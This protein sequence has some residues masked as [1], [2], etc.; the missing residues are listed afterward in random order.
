[1]TRSLGVAA[2]PSVR[3]A[4]ERLRNAA[5]TARRGWLPAKWERVAGPG[6]DVLA[7]TPITIVQPYGAFPDLVL[8]PGCELVLQCAL[9]I[10]AEIAN[11]PTAGDTLELTVNSLYPI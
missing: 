8:E 9:D 11:V 1:M 6:P 10:P 2:T 7:M 4:L 5:D 3:A